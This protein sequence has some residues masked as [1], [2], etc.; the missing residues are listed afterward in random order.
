VRV[1]L[2]L[3]ERTSSGHPLR[4][5]VDVRLTREDAERL[6][7]KCAGTIPDSHHTSGSRSVSL[8]AGGRN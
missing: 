3:D 8:E 6:L 2:I 4:E 5:A 7:P 1:Y